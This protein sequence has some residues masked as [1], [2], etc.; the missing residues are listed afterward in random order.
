MYATIEDVEDDRALVNND[1]AVIDFE[2]KLD[3]EARK[4]L[5]SEDYTLEI[6]SGS[7]VPGFEEQL[8]GMKKGES[9]DITV[10]FPEEY[11]AKDIA[12][13]EVLFSVTLKNIREKILPELNEEFVKNFE[14]YESLEDLKKDIKKSLEEEG[15]A[16]IK[17]DLRNAMIDKLLEN[18]EFEVPSAWVERQV[19][20]MMLD[21]RQR[22]TQNGMPDDKASE[23]SYNLHEGFKDPAT[24]IVKASFIFNEIAKKESIEVTEKDIEDKLNVLAQRY[25]QDYESVKKAYGTNNME[26]RL[27]EELLEQ[28][29][30]DF[31]EEKANITFVKKD[32]EKGEK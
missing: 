16:R 23:I 8:V 29:A 27:K 10:T 26:D 28:K 12:G 20:T 7:F 3:G 15:E 19:Y 2:G 4:E 18:N 11:G 5:A 25:A 9:K 13:K 14:K 22:M 31:I 30:M 24:R 6:G 32:R 21:A 17:T 1:F